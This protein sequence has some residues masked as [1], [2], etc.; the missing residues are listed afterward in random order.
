[1][2]L[3]DQPPTPDSI[4]IED[5]AAAATE[6][7]AAFDHLARLA[8]AGFIT[9]REEVPIAPEQ[10]A[11]ST[12]PRAASLRG[13]VLAELIV[14]AGEAMQGRQEWRHRSDVEVV[15]PSWLIA[16]PPI[17]RALP[18]KDQPDGSP[19]QAAERSATG[20]VIEAA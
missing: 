2:S 7:G 15:V 8:L 12:E 4:A 3:V 17:E 9:V 1:M 16:A 5:S 18:E 20:A 14:A 6:P 10:D 11:L 19:E 13:R